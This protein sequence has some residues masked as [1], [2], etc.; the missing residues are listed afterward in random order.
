M[1]FMVTDNIPK[2]NTNILINSAPSEGQ[3]NSQNL[4]KIGLYDESTKKMNI[5]T[6]SIDKFLMLTDAVSYDFKLLGIKLDIKFRFEDTNQ[7]AKNDEESVQNEV[8]KPLSRLIQESSINSDDPNVSMV[9]VFRP[10]SVLG[11]IFWIGI[12]FLTGMIFN[13]TKLKQGLG[14]NLRDLFV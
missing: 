14:F 13:V 5:K 1:A 8:Q 7:E 12:F 4:F 2:A 3:Q 10:I 6:Y 9:S 11:W